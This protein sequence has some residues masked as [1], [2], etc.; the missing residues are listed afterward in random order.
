M[1]AL[2]AN[3]SRPVMFVISKFM[4]ASNRATK[5]KNRVQNQAHPFNVHNPQKRINPMIPMIKGISAN[6]IPSSGSM[7]TTA[8]IN[9]PARMASSDDISCSSANIITP[10]GLTDI[11]LSSEPQ[12]SGVGLVLTCVSSYKINVHIT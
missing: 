8:S 3:E 5:L 10:V 2:R 12:R 11:C 6:I 9:T 7:N 1:I 4:T